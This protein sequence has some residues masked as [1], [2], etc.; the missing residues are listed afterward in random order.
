MLYEPTK[1]EVKQIKNL[2][3]AY[4]MFG[5]AFKIILNNTPN[6]NNIETE[7]YMANK[8]LEAMNKRIF[9]LLEKKCI[10]QEFFKL[11]KN[12]NIKKN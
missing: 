6:D 4:K 9:E 1:K 2:N 8:H 10:D 12:L 7:L 3:K 5:I 11:V